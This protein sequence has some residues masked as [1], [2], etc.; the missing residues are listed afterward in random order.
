MN[1]IFQERHILIM[2][3]FSVRHKYC[4]LVILWFLGSSAISADYKIVDRSDKRIRL[5]FNLPQPK[6][7]TVDTL[8]AVYTDVRLADWEETIVNGCKIPLS[9]TTISSTTKNTH[10]KIVSVSEQ[11]KSLPPPR[12]WADV[13]LGAENLKPGRSAPSQGTCP[14]E[15]LVFQATGCFRDHHLF[16]VQVFP[17]RYNF[18]A[19]QY[20]IC[21]QITLDIYTDS[22]SAGLPLSGA[23]NKDA[24]IKSLAA[25]SLFGGKNSPVKTRK[26]M[27]QDTRTRCKILIDSDG[28]YRVTGKDLQSAGITLLNID[29]RSLELLHRGGPVPVYVKGWR[30]GQ[31]H[32]NDYIEFWGTYNR[33][34]QQDKS[35]DL[36][37]DP[38]TQTNVYWLAWGRQRGQWLAEEQTLEIPA[39]AGYYRPFAYY[40]TAHV[41]KNDFFDRLNRVPM[42]SVRDHWFYDTGIGPQ[43]KR[44]Y[45]CKLTHP[46]EQ[47]PLAVRV[48]IVATGRTNNDTLRHN[49]SAYLNDSFINSS[50]WYGQDFICMQTPET[51]DINGADLQHGTNVVTIMNQSPA[52]QFD[53]IMLNW[54][55]IE[56]PRLYR[57]ENNFIRFSTPP[58]QPTG[59][60]LFQIDGFTSENIDIY[61][62]GTSKIIG[63]QVKDILDR[64]GEHS[65]QVGFY[66][67]SASAATEYVAIAA[68]E[69]KKPRSIIKDEPSFLKNPQ[70]SADYLVISHRRFVDVPAL[71]DLIQHRR[72][73]GL[74]VL[75]IDVQNI[76]DE[77]NHGIASPFAIKDFLTYAYHHWADPKPQYVLM[78][79]DGCYQNYKYNADGDSLEFINLLPVYMRQTVGFG[80]AASD[81]WYTLVAGDDEIPDMFIGRFPVRYPEQLKVLVDKI[82]SAETSTKKDTWCNRLVYIGGDGN[83]FRNQGN[84]LAGRV[85]PRFE[86]NR[87]YTYRDPNVENDPHFGGSLQLFEYFNRGCAVISFHGHGGGAIWADQGLLTL[88]NIDNM[89]TNG[90][91]PLILSM[92]CF[93]GAFESP[94]NN[95]LADAMLFAPE[96]GTTMVFGASGTGWMWNDHYL[97][98]SILDY[99]YENP[100][101]N[102]GQVITAGKINY[103]ARY[104]NSETA[105]SQMN[106]YHILGDPAS[107]LFLPAKEAKVDIQNPLSKI[108]QSIEVSA[109]CPFTDGTGRFYMVDSTFNSVFETESDVVDGVAQARLTV[110][111]AYKHNQGHVRFFAIDELGTA[112]VNGADIFSL[113]DVLFDSANVTPARGDSLI[114]RVRLLSKKNIQNLYCLCAGDT[115]SMRKEHDDWY[116]GG[117]YF[118][119]AWSGYELPY[120]FRAVTDGISTSPTFKYYISYGFDLGIEKNTVQLG[121]MER[122][123]LST[124]IKNYGDQKAVDIP[125]AFYHNVDGSFQYLSKD[126][127]TLEPFATGTAQIPFSAAPG[128]A[129]IKVIIDPDSLYHEADRTNNTGTADIKVTGFN[130]ETNKGLAINGTAG[131]SLHF[132]AR[133]SI[134]LSPGTFAEN[135]AIHIERLDTLSIIEQPLFTQSPGYHAYSIT[136]AYLQQ[137]EKPVYLSFRPDSLTVPPADQSIYR[138]VEKTGKWL[139]LPTTTNNRQSTAMIEEFGQIAVLMGTDA[140]KPNIDFTVDGQPYTPNAYCSKKPQLSFLLQ[141]ENGI[142]ISEETL[143]LSLNG[144]PQPTD[145]PEVIANGNQM[146]LDIYPALKTG[147][148]VLTFQAADCYGNKTE[149]LEILLQVAEDFDIE[150]LGNYPNPFSRHTT[151]AYNLSRPCEELGLKIYTASGRLIRHLDPRHF[152]E[153][154]NPFGADYHE[155]FWDGTDEHGDAVANGVYFYRISAKVSGKTVQK[156]GKLARIK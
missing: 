134:C 25:E 131:D 137:F 66:D 78:V 13:P 100:Q 1:S 149:P 64:Y 105:V 63:A 90:R 91:F 3:L 15:C 73:Q 92:T 83:I 50:S 48:K 27:V 41:E 26:T 145:I 81:H 102:L 143:E 43:K 148:N 21:S 57:A 156:T 142:D 9:T 85:P 117:K 98:K 10:A 115:V 75:K 146:M 113:Q 106:Q 39:S 82:I 46:D 65:F 18:T 68:G 28:L 19:G 12:P 62:L 126:F 42:D 2:H 60:L 139:R 31:F 38:Y 72:D 5:Q 103:L 84:E 109:L 6:F 77:F 55:Q 61:K 54:L 112:P 23:A 40:H 86:N 45:Y 155:L 110:P 56:Y 34:T 49:M 74:R 129:G 32:E 24:F 17:V 97:L 95:S 96:Q 88:E 70:L 154:P 114:F 7:E 71:D 29:I 122:V 14:A 128:R 136:T 119:P 22:P 138:F 59:K 80:S 8:G 150:L 87:L 94:S 130:Y 141:D 36:Y 147:R 124:K 127:I 99:L 152:S 47:S 89:Q 30:D 121:G 35:P 52:D 37:Q 132:D 93:T 123:L 104:F 133:F 116:R 151:F 69:K 58:E 120:R 53:Y 33:Q 76:F 135:C 118:S 20:I 51:A 79:G 16:S 67:K 108:G 125:V 144:K 101:K 111:T 107:R 11:K 153:A 4:F 140:E 44:N